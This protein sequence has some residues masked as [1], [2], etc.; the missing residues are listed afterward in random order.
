MPLS[1]LSFGVQR[2]HNPVV[3]SLICWSD[4]LEVEGVS[5]SDFYRECEEAIEDRFCALFEEHKYHW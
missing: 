2:T 4:F 5:S 1:L 3:R